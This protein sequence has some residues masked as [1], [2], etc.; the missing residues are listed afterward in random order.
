MPIHSST[1]YSYAK[2]EYNMSP[3]CTP[4]IQEGGLRRVLYASYRQVYLLRTSLTRWSGV[5]QQKVVSE[6]VQ[7]ILIGYP[8]P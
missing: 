8:P 4:C 7:A 2:C 3:L 1:W 6:D 5:C